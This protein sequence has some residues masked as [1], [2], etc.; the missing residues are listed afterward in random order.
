MLSYLIRPLAVL[1]LF[2]TLA[3]C[4][5]APKPPVR[6]IGVTNA[7]AWDAS[8]V[9]L[10]FLEVR[11]PTGRTVNIKRL[12]YRMN[13]QPW[14]DASGFVPVSR[15]IIAGGSA[16]IEVPVRLDENAKPVGPGEIAYRFQGTLEVRSGSTRH[17]WPVSAEGELSTKAGPDDRSAYIVLP[18]G[19][20]RE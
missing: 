2:A 4:G 20:T 6:V 10:V 9:L 16:I 8:P 13:A 7:H 19:S 12:D 14:F 18:A 15:S 11:N 3:A 5:G 1:S 17:K